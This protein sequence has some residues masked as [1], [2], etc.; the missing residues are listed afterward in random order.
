MT[1]WVRRGT[2]PRGWMVL[3]QII[4]CYGADVGIIMPRHAVL[5]VGLM[6]SPI[7]GLMSS[8]FAW[9]P[10]NDVA[11]SNVEALVGGEYVMHFHN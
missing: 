2:A 7:N 5:P 3:E 11:R 6:R 9:L 1:M 10:A 8:D 4:E